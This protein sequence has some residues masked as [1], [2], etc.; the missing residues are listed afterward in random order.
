[1]AATTITAAAATAAT[2][3][4][5]HGMTPFPGLLSGASVFFS[6][7]ISAAEVFGS[8]AASWPTLEPWVF[9]LPLLSQ[10][11]AKLQLTTNA[12]A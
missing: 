11:F 6:S 8:N 4:A 5:L 7:G 2:L 12:A 3:R 9:F 10:V 1:L